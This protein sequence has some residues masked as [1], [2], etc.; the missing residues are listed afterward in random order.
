VEAPNGDGRAFSQKAKLEHNLL[1]VPGEE[2]EC[3]GFMRLSY[4]VSNNMIRRSLPAFEAM[5]HSYK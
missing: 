5:I 2:F 4:C 1:V 3:P